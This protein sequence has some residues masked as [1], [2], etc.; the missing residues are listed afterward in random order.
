M[1]SRSPLV[2]PRSFV[3]A[4]AVFLLAPLAAAGHIPTGSNDPSPSATGLGAT[5]AAIDASGAYRS[6]VPFDLPSYHDIGPSLSL[7]YDSAHGNGW[8]GVGWTLAGV[9]TIQRSS[10]VRGAPRYRTDDVFLLDGSRLLRCRRKTD[11]PSCK[12]PASRKYDAYTQVIEGFKRIAFVPGHGDGKWLVWTTTGTVLT[13]LPRYHGTG[14]SAYAWDLAEMRDTSGNRVLF[15]WRVGLPVTGIGESYLGT[16]SY[17]PVEV[18]LRYAD[19]PD[20]FT[21]GTGADLV[22]VG[23]RLT[24]VE[25]R[26]ESRLVR[27][28]ELDYHT[29]G[30]TERSVLEKVRQ[31]GSDAVICTT[32]GG[33][34]SYGAVT[35]GTALPP[36]TLRTPS[37]RAGL[38]AT[39]QESPTDMTAGADTRIGPP[40][41]GQPYDSRPYQVRTSWLQTSADA[42]QPRVRVAD[43]NGDGRDDVMVLRVF[44]DSTGLQHEVLSSAIATRTGYKLFDFEPDPTNMDETIGIQADYWAADADGDGMT[45]II[46]I[47]LD[48]RLQVWRSNGD[49]TFTRTVD[50]QLSWP[51]EQSAAS[52]FTFGVSVG[53]G[54]GSYSGTASWNVYSNCDVE[55]EQQYVVAD[56]NGDGRADV[57]GVSHNA[58]TNTLTL[59]TALSTGTDYTVIPDDDTTEPWTSTNTRKDR[60]FPADINGDGRAD[61][62]HIG[63]RATPTAHSSITMAMSQGNG[64]FSFTSEQVGGPWDDED[65]WY[66]GDV[67]GDGRADI[68][69]VFRAGSDSTAHFD[70]ASFTVALTGEAGNNFRMVSGSAAIPWYRSAPFGDTNHYPTPWLVGDIDGDRRADIVAVAEATNSAGQPSEDLGVIFSRPGD[71]FAV[72]PRYLT[73]VE[74]TAWNWGAP[75]SIPTHLGDVNGDGKQD[76]VLTPYRGR[77]FHYPLDIIT[78]LSPNRGLDTAN[79]RP[80]DVDGDG[81]EDYVYVY[82]RNP[83]YTVYTLRRKPNGTFA[84]IE[85]GVD[86]VNMPG[87]VADLNTPDTT[88]WIVA[89]VGGGP[90]KSADGRADLVYVDQVAGRRLT[91]YSLLSLGDGKWRHQAQPFLAPP[92]FDPSREERDWL[93]ADVNGDGRTDLIN[94]AHVGGQAVV[95]TLTSTGDGFWVLRSSTQFAAL[96]PGD[97]PNW[98]TGDVNGDGRADLALVS[99]ESGQ[100]KVRTL[101]SDP[102]GGW[103]PVAYPV[104]VTTFADARR[105]MTIEANGDGLTDLAYLD[106]FG[107]NIRL[108]VMTSLGNGEWRP[109]PVTPL[110]LPTGVRLEDAVAFRRA[111]VNRDGRTDLIHLSN[112]L[113]SSGAL[114]TAVMLLVHNGSGWTLQNQR[115]I[116][117]SAS[118]IPR[119]QISDADGDGLSDLTL[120]PDAAGTAS[121]SIEALRL[122]AADDQVVQL[123]NPLGGITDVAYK[124]STSWSAN[125]SHTPCALPLGVTRSTVSSVKTSDGRSTR[126]S[127]VSYSYAC[128]RWSHTE[129][130]FLGW[131]QVAE[132]RAGSANQPP[133]TLLNVYEITDKCLTRPSYQ[134][135]HDSAGRAITK[136]IIAYLPAGGAPYHCLTNYVDNIL[137]NQSRTAPNQYTYYSY[138]QFGNVTKLY[139]QGDPGVTTDDRSIIHAFRAATKPYV[140]AL[141]SGEELRAGP[142]SSYPLLRVRMLCYDG[143][144]SLTCEGTPTKGR[145]TAVKELNMHGLSDLAVTEL[146]YDAQGDIA[147]LRDPNNHVSTVFYDPTW[148][149]Y[150]VKVCDPLQRCQDLTWDPVSGQLADISDVNGH[151]TSYTYDV[152]GRLKTVTPGGAATMTRTYKDWGRPSRQ[153]VRDSI[154]DSSPSGLWQESYL[155]GLGRTY[156]EVSKGDATLGPVQQTTLYL[157]ATSLPVEITDWFATTQTPKREQFSY[158]A[159]GRLMLQVHA[160]GTTLKWRYNADANTTSI[161]STDE[162]GHETTVYADAWGRT[163]RTHQVVGGQDSDVRYSYT[164]ADDLRTITDAAGNVTTFTIDNRGRITAVTDP[165]RG[166]W[167]YT[168]DL[169]GNVLTR[170]D[171]AQRTVTYTYD[172]LDRIKTKSDPDGRL[173]TWRYDEAGHSDGLGRLTSVTD[174]AEPLCPGGVTF[175]Y[176]YDQQGNATTTRQ[177]INGYTAE[178]GAAYDPL[179]RQRS[180]TYPDGETI[181]YHYDRAGR[182]DKLPGLVDLIQY[183]A[184]GRLSTLDYA[185]GT[186]AAYDIDPKRGWV[187]EA[188]LTAGARTLYEATYTHYDDGTIKTIRSPTNAM[189]VDY[190]YDELGRLATVAG[191]L[192][193]TIGYDVTGNITTNS[194]VGTY[195]YATAASTTRCGLRNPHPCPHA[196]ADTSGPAGTET[197]RYDDNGNLTFA[198]LTAGGVTTTRSIEWNADSLPI[199]MR[200]RSGVTT[201]IR[202]DAYGRRVYRERGGEVTLYLDDLVDVA[203]PT[204]GGPIRVTKHYYAG[205]MQVATANA[206][207]ITWQTTDQLGSPRL[208]IDGQANSVERTDYQPHGATVGTTSRPLV[209]FAGAPPDNDNGLIYLG[210]RYYDP[211]LGR[212]I[213]ADPATPISDDSQS[214]NPYAYAENN[215]VSFTDPT[216]MQACVAAQETC[217]AVPETPNPV[218][219]FDPV[220]IEGR[221]VP[222]EQ[223]VHVSCPNCTFFPDPSPAPAENPPAPAAH[224][225][226]LSEAMEQNLIHEG[227]V[228]AVTSTG[229]PIQAK[230][231]IDETGVTMFGGY[232]ELANAQAQGLGAYTEA[233]NV[234]NAAANKVASSGIKGGAG[235]AALPTKGG[236]SGNGTPPP[237]GTPLTNRQLLQEVARRA[238][239]K[240]GGWGAVAGTRKHTYARRLLDRYQSLFGN[241]GLETEVSFLNGVRVPYGT[242]GSVR[243]DVLEAGAQSVFDYKFVLNPPGLRT[244]QVTRILN[245]VPGIQHVIEINP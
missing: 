50:R 131:E 66:P 68:V 159:A 115:D 40:W 222:P 157:G 145:L 110:A 224:Q 108:H 75:E 99:A 161:V 230:P 242:A 102:R 45:D 82:F 195:T 121:G 235:K 244:G 202:Y 89:D 166:T 83:G 179:G 34:C 140:V 197:Y 107:S 223:R 175:W 15:H 72:D 228:D 57:F 125:Q 53:V 143:D 42:F 21:Y 213:S 160:D 190:T 241:R 69:H 138:D 196:L 139:Q 120:L 234:A 185:N 51:Y 64:T 191:D 172:A 187:N 128:A 103:E 173:I 214:I 233:A 168:L 87:L 118:A 20:P 109:E 231:E 137:L 5:T 217:V 210:A 153:R 52:C 112:N 16:I 17:G 9:S 101:I 90:G 218:M 28:Y 114:K 70:H 211:R 165:D 193:Q 46:Q 10:S 49:G 189:N 146:A 2:R 31:F 14:G 18:T 135:L 225:M 219:R 227:H 29:S 186:H 178:I 152:L 3:Y 226:T 182:L 141:P 38:G 243:I 63:F 55:L 22:Y 11:S 116:G 236:P 54:A 200:D 207:G 100:T 127:V 37:M 216:G 150:P 232:A 203:Y 104:T 7:L 167:T 94:V 61:L 144:Q 119:W 129:G 148:H 174:S 62:V 126:P 8:V 48:K 81:H 192:Q 23:E 215:P 74:P 76:L 77:G 240:V 111:D 198:Q 184:S 98:Q 136:T 41:P 180:L 36:V 133:S 105:W 220:T 170:T 151:H 67:N 164:G 12:Y 238:E 24:S 155:D 124:S 162:L 229:M 134:Q 4:V 1:V 163:V 132:R 91:V 237:S 85:D 71:T 58:T 169:V 26:V 35:S 56:V 33:P 206:T 158:D 212:F 27:A 177:C 221:F 97:G 30:S 88:R 19:R 25:V 86:F 142:D 80:A 43:I 201:T 117:I 194:S 156:R 205:T 39:W 204:G 149:L 73:E 147:A 188:S 47:T 78:R 181:N 176:A 96:S 79:W 113:D 59:H 130:G 199:E 13:Y 95:H 245:N 44:T 123:V 208:R 60:F 154:A 65:V 171:A 93:P 106:I 183:D 122:P 32:R 209:G 92:E 6:E 239:Q 84:R